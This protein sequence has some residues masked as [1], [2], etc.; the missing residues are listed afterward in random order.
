MDY[1]N[2][3]SIAVLLVSAAG[4]SYSLP[5]NTWGM[6]LPSDDIFSCPDLKPQPSL[7]LQEV[8]VLRINILHMYVF[9][10]ELLV[11]LLLL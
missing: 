10:F 2:R 9:M 7:D 11:L 3:I 1:Y 6:N 5:E 4:I 8:C